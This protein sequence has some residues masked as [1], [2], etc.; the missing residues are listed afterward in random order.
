MMTDSSDRYGQ[1][2]HADDISN[3]PKDKKKQSLTSSQTRKQNAKIYNTTVKNKS[4]TK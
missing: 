2:V 1:K 4:Y 3:T